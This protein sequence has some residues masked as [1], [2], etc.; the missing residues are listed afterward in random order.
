MSFVNAILFISAVARPDVS[1]RLGALTC[2]EAPDNRPI[3]AWAVGVFD[4][5]ID[6]R[7]AE[8][9]AG[10]SPTE[11][12]LA[13][14][15]HALAQ[16]R[17]YQGFA[18]GLCAD[19][20]GWAAA[21]PAPEPLNILKDG[22]ISLPTALDTACESYRVDFAAT[23][24]DAPRALGAP[25]TIDPKTLG[26]G[27][28]S[29]TCQPPKPRFQGP[30]LWF[31]APVG[32]G[33]ATELPAAAALAEGRGTE[34]QLIAWVNAVRRGEA[35]KPLVFTKEMRG[36]ASIL[37]IDPTLTHNRAML[38]KV[39]ESLASGSVRLIGEDRVKG[40]DAAAMAWLLWASPRHRDLLLDKKATV[41]GIA[42][43]VTRGETLAVLL[44][45]E[46]EPLKTA[47]VPGRGAK[48]KSLK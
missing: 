24:G 2:A 23:A 21:M 48:S 43:V 30:V 13:R 47:R 35:L 38:R 41:A 39:G 32:K 15:A 12:E 14:K 16:T 5:Q 46:D 1:A 9:R 44:V 28:V 4:A 40:R 37:A 18:H 17:G 6:G 45:G 26:D 20:T 29:V 3:G 10:R 27:V 22:T 34:E 31:L 19:G 42:T 36:E 7:K 8:I 25:K 33:P 11:E